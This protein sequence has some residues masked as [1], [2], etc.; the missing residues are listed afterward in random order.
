VRTS[1]A[2]GACI[3]PISF[4]SSSSRLGS[5]AS[6]LTSLADIRFPGMAP[7][8]MTKSS[9][10]LANSDITFAPATGSLEMPYIS[11]PDSSAVSFSNGVP[12][13]ARRARVFF[14]TRR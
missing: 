11:G 8:L 9:L 13:T 5:S 14:S 6:A 4:A 10:S 3:V 2:T 12:W 1:L 7:A